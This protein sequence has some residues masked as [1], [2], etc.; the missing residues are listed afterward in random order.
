[1]TRRDDDDRKAG[2][3]ARE[4]RRMF[5]LYVV[6]CAMLAGPLIFLMFGDNN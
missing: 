5:L 3:K 4:G 1:M 6:L 2:E